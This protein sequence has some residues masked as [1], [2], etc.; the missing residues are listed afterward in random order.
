MSRLRLYDLWFTNSLL[1][2]RR[3]VAVS[4]ADHGG[5]SRNLLCEL[6]V[7][8]RSF[9]NRSSPWLLAEAHYWAVLPPYVLP[10]NS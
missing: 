3:D 9:N 6:T 1:S 8:D 7:I 4:K 10:S 5:G 2:S